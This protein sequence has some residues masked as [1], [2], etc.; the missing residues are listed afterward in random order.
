MPADV[1]VWNEHE[2]PFAL[3]ADW[4]KAHGAGN[5][6]VGVE[7]TTRFFAFDGLRKRGVETRAD[8]GVVRACR[9]IKSP[10]EIALMQAAAT[11]RS[12]PIARRLRRSRAA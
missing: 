1:R 3:L 5:G 9:I 4:L 7:E 11:S 10:A 12:P 6:P 2:S 8:S